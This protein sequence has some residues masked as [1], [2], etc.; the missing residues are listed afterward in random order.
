[1][2]RKAITFS[3]LENDNKKKEKRE[4]VNMIE[5][6]NELNSESNILV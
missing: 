6:K 5:K 1:M 3:W 2:R 4:T